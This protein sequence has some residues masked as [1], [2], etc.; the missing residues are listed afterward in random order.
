MCREGSRF[1]CYAALFT[2]GWPAKCQHLCSEQRRPSA[3]NQSRQSPSVVCPGIESG[4]YRLITVF[5]RPHRQTVRRL[6]VGM[7]KNVSKPLVCN[8]TASGAIV[9]PMTHSSKNGFILYLKRNGIIIIDCVTPEITA[10][11][12]VQWITQQFIFILEL[13]S[14]R[15]VSSPVHEAGTKLRVHRERKDRKSPMK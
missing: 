4:P 9:R 8:V 11:Q 3:V 2:A 12:L 14:F 13:S 5:I 15:L 6:D 10:W 1:I 7:M